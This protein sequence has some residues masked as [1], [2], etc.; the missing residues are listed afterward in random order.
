[1][2]RGYDIGTAEHA[3]VRL[4]YPSKDRT[5]AER[6]LRAALPTWLTGMRTAV[7]IAVRGG[8]TVRDLGEHVEALLRAQ[9]IGSP[10]EVAAGLAESARTT[11]VRRQLC[12]VEATAS[13]GATAEP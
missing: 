11:G 6:E 2:E 13:A 8:T 3:R 4:A 7:R 5:T 9:P 12:M 1:M 10:A